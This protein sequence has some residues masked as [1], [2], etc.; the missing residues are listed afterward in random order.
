[1]AHLCDTVHVL[2]SLHVCMLPGFCMSPLLIFDATRD[3]A[4]A[5]TDPLPFC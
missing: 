4:S 1:M 2:N 3:F 5:R